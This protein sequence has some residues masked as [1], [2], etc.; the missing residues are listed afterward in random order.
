VQSGAISLVQGGPGSD[1]C[2]TPLPAGGAGGAGGSAHG[3]KGARFRTGVRK[4]SGLVEI[5]YTPNCS[6][7]GA[8]CITTLS[9]PVDA[10]A[11]AGV[12]SA[13]VS[14]GAPKH[15]N[16]ISGYEVS[17]SP[18]GATVHA[19]NSPVVIKDLKDGTGYTFKVRAENEIGASP[20]AAV[21]AT[22]ADVPAAPSGVA[23]VAGDNGVAVV[24]FSAPASPYSAI[25]HYTVTAS[26]VGS[27]AL[28]ATAA[29]LAAIGT[30]SPIT[31]TGLNDGVAYTFRV[32][33][34][35]GVGVGASSASSNPVTPVGLP[36]PPVNAVAIAG[37]EQATVS[38][39]ASDPD[40]EPI[41]QYAVSASPGDETATGSGAPITVTGLSPG[42]SYT[43]TV[44]ATSAFGTSKPSNPS[45][46][47]TVFGLPGAPTGVSG[48]GGNAAATISFSAAPANGSPITQYTATA[49]PG[50]A[51]GTGSASP[52]KVGS[53]TN[54]TAYTF[55]VV[56]TNAAGTGP[57]SA[58]SAAVTPLWVPG[59]PTDVV[60]SNF[61]TST[62]E[63]T[64][65]APASD[66]GSAIEGYK[67]TGTSSDGGATASGTTT[68]TSAFIKGA[69]SG[70]T[71]T[72]TV[73]A[74]N[75]VGS[76]PASA[77]SNAVTAGS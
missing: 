44:T 61:N 12:R 11:T 75:T 35:N 52:I 24:A 7:G 34:T 32:T 18:G 76:G 63:V 66:G 25:K 45:A 59:A 10:A 41:A 54:G 74:M 71:Y 72:F 60:A 21:H 2:S 19:K 30:G 6:G 16:G 51:T 8:A 77:A 37:N 13:T 65:S 68:D 3:P 29:G 48:T 40:G 22:P 20:A 58:V 55:T 39:A 67:V 1:F 14:F 53:L 47:V 33:A 4:G 43:F 31:V 5:S 62:I 73:T 28:S 56:A 36:T 57:P 38:F 23:A 15:G 46:A 27:A 26:A 50:G 17:V 64:F 42:T 70:D 49:S 9:A 69:T